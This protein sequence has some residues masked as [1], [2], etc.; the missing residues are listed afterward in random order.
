[1]TYVIP[2]FIALVLI[3]AFLKKVTCYDTFAD[4]AMEG[5]KFAFTVFPYL[6]AIFVFIELIKASGV[7]DV[8]ISVCAPVFTFFGIP[9]ELAELIILRPLSGNGSLAILDTLI[10]EHGADSYIAR[11]AAVITSAAET[12]FYVAAVY[13]STVKVKKMRFIIPISLFAS[14]LGAIVACV[15]CR[16]I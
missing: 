14:M 2:I 6:A 10:A 8:L 11:S 12:V 4:G 7:A 5:L 1:M 16:F 15:L 9:A 13:F 3:V